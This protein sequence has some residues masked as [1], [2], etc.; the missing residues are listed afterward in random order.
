MCLLSQNVQSA[1]PDSENQSHETDIPH[2]D[3][4]GLSRKAIQ[5]IEVSQVIS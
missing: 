4:G 3:S 5:S 2:L 1:P